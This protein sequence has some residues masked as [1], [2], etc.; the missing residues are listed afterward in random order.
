[1]YRTDL[2]GLADWLEY[3]ADI[4][5]NSPYPKDAAW[6]DKLKGWARCVRR[7]LAALDEHPSRRSLQERGH[8]NRGERDLLRDMPILPPL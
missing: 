3:N 8:G 5:R 1:M 6:G 2:R 4:R 7:A